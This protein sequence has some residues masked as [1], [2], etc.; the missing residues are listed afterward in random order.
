V[1]V[2]HTTPTRALRD[3]STGA[4]A[5]AEPPV[6]LLPP[7]LGTELSGRLERAGRGLRSAVASF[8]DLCALVLDSLVLTAR[9]VA[10]G[11]FPWREFVDQAWFLAA[12]S[13]VPTILIA[14][15]IGLVIVLEVGSLANQIGATSFIGAVDAIGTVR[16]VAP[17][18]TALLLSGAGG[19][20]ICSD[21]GA[22]TIRD[23]IA[24][25]QVMGIDPVERLVAPRV[26]ATVVVA[27]LLNGIVAFAG[28]LSGYVAAVTVLGSTAGGF[29]NSFSIFAQPADIVESMIKAVI[30]AVIAA[31]V[32]SYKGLGVR[33]G[34]AGVGEAVN[35]SVVI[36]GVVL[37]LVNLLI[38]DIFLVL[39]PPRI[40]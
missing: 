18:V 33:R 9:A 1:Q 29:L 24:A 2:Q 13:V 35:Q 36:T 11:R 6:E 12:V 32:A 40:V 37:F 14:I 22:R 10:R 38:T 21:L 23:E 7:L 39:V 16:E 25:L 31:T 26:L 15:P 20:A 17:I 34:P 27:V 8:G 4:P 30:F 19:S 3:G 28:I 5:P